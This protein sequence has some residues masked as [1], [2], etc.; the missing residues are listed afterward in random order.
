MLHG[1]DTQRAQR[2]RSKNR[3]E[4]RACIA[5]DEFVHFIERVRFARRDDDDSMLPT[6]DPYGIKRQDVRCISIRLG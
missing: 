3:Y 5:C 4:Q 1:H 6:C 2:N